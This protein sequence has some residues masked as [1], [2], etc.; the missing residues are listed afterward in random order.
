MEAEKRC[1]SLELVL[2][3]TLIFATRAGAAAG[4]LDPTFGTNGV[5]V[6]DLGGPSDIGGNIVL[7][8]DGKIVMAG[9]AELDLNFP[10]YRTPVIVRYKPD[11]T[12]DNTFGTSGKVTAPIR[13]L[14][15]IALQTDG[16]LVGGGSLNGGF[17]LA[18]YTSTGALDNAFGTSGVAIAGQDGNFNL[19]FGDLAIQADGKIVVVGTQET[20]G[21]TYPG[22]I[23]RFNENGTLDRD[24]R[25]KFFDDT[26]FPDSL[27]HYLRAVA[28]QP[29]GKII[30][31]GD[32]IGKEGDN[33]IT[34]GRITTGP[35]PWLDPTFGTNGQGTVVTPLAHFK[36]GQGA[37]AIQADGKI[38]IAGTMTDTFN[39]LNENLVL[40]RFNSDGTL[41][42]T[43]GGSGIVITELDQNE[44]GSDVAIQTDGKI[45]VVGT[46]YNATTSDFLLVRYNSDGSLDTTFG[47]GGKVISDLGSSADSARGVVLQADGKILTVGSKDEDA[48]LA[49]YSVSTVPLPT[50]TAVFKSRGSQDGWI[51]ESGEDTSAGGTL[52]RAATTFNVGDDKRDRQYRAI[53]SFNTASLPGNATI[54]SAQV[55]VK[56][57]GLVGIDPF[58]T[59]GKLLLEIRNGLFGNDFDLKLGDFAADSSSVTQDTFVGLT[60][61][62][63]TAKVGYSNLAFVNKFGVTQFRLRFNLDDNDDLGADYI[64]FFA[65]DAQ[66]SF[67][68][69]LNITYTLP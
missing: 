65:G 26:N 62:W 51:L 44:M 3:A 24:F 22:A 57:Q 69:Q 8:P 20:G 43:L 2:I 9:S 6:T 37:L 47:D 29:D 46:R 36:H 12:L 60:Y 19:L 18:R 55:N 39:P 48:A 49:R 56:R 23:A 63:Y 33:Y 1:V 41:D 27:Q 50:K 64:K 54:T 42:T 15:R 40:A 17:A 67:Q 59:H 16:K 13:G 61:S 53:I 14:A 68:P 11:G 30:M 10:G 31:A 52:N 28:L 21:H 5:V 58:L 32:M 25:L 7:Q 45:V 38:V 34:L 66:D 4:T 35:D